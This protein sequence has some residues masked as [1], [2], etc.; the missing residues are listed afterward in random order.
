MR[1][2]DVGLWIEARADKGS[3]LLI[4]ARVDEGRGLLNNLVAA[5]EGGLEVSPIDDADDSLWLSSEFLDGD[6]SCEYT[7]Y[8][9]GGDRYSVNELRRS[10][11]SLSNV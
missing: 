7:E 11:W 3:G 5:E 1:V 10:R 2:D 4:E 8:S 9:S 6:E